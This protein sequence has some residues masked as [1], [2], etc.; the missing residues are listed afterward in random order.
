[1]QTS[2]LRRFV[3]ANTRVSGRFD[4][5]KDLELYR[6]YD[7]HVAEAIRALRS[8]ATVVDVGGGRTCSFAGDVSPA[9][10]I[11]VIAVDVSGEELRANT[12]VDATYVANVAEHL[13]FS[14]AEIDLL[15][16]RTVLEHVTDVE[17]AA[18]EMGRV[19]RSGSLCI[20]LL[21]CRYALFAIVARIVPFWIAKAVLH[22]IVPE[23]RGVV[24]F[25]VHY[26]RCHPAAIERLFRDAGF[27]SVEIEC[28]WDQAAYFH[29]CFPLFLLVLAYQR[30]AEALQMR[31]L[32]SYIIVRAT[33]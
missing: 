2:V 31:H 20:H 8:G 24:E 14:D 19:L 21:P 32:A 25:D 1:M 15:V 29:A 33:R 12:C 9:A 18:S 4:R 28:T 13:P 10:A 17:R 6:R 23:S 27:A 30:I 16:S 3:D 22:R 5:R 26:D 11:R 7:R